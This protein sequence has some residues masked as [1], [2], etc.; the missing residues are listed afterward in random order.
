MSLRLNTEHL[1]PNWWLFGEVWE[2]KPCCRKCVTGVRLY[3]LKKKKKKR[4][5]R[6]FRWTVQVQ[7]HVQAN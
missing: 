4:K 5:R 6:E 2:V 3:D 7:R 1:V